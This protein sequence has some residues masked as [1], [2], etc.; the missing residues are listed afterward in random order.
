M[1]DVSADALGAAS[2]LA[3]KLAAMELFNRDSEAANR[4]AERLRL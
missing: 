2:R 3:D 1:V 4:I